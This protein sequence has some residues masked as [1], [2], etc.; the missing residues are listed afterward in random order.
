MKALSFNKWNSLNESII[1]WKEREGLQEFYND[2][3]RLLDLYK[4]RANVNHIELND[5]KSIGEHNGIEIVTYDEFLD[6]LPEESKHTAPPRQAGLFALVNPETGGP[7][8][9]ISVPRIGKREIDH[10]F[11]MLKHEAIHIGQYS[12]RPD[13]IDTS[14]IDPKDSGVYF[15][16]KDEVMAFSHSIAD[17][18]ISSGRYDNAEDAMLDLNT[19]RLYSTIKKSVDENTLKRYHKYIYMYLQNELN[20]SY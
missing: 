1:D 5:I 15:S 18:L 16:N 4:E 7:R 2:S 12:R 19:V 6:E 14:L 10:I 20:T 13:D 9:V 3:I 11:H 8:V 17:M